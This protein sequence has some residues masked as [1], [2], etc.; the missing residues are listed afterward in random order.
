MNIHFKEHSKTGEIQIMN[1]LLA[2]TMTMIF[3]GMCILYLS[4]LEKLRRKQ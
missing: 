1:D 4:G 2:I 3:F